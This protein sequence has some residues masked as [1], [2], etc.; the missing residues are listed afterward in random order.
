MTGKMVEMSLKGYKVEQLSDLSFTR[1]NYNSEIDDFFENSFRLSKTIR[2][3]DCRPTLRA[4]YPT[5]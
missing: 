2:F 4:S 3:A 5:K 1:V